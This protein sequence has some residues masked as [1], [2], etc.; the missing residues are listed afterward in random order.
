MIQLFSVLFSVD[1]PIVNQISSFHS[2]S[3]RVNSLHI[4]IEIK[5]SSALFCGQFTNG[6][7]VQHR[8]CDTT[9]L[10][11][12]LSRLVPAKNRFDYVIGYYVFSNINSMEW[13]MSRWYVMPFS[14]MPFERFTP[15][16]LT[17]Y[18]GLCLTSTADSIRG[19]WLIA[20]P[21]FL[22]SCPYL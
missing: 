17:M 1:R 20:T 5:F 16:S 9:E 22:F 3:L 13:P 7:N 11:A 10:I 18:S 12:R 8:C 15:L 19:Y 21:I 14:L 6:R 2:L 4:P